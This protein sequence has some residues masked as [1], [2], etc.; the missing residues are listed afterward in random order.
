MGTRA[1][2]AATFVVGVLVET[3]TAL[4]RGPFAEGGAFSGLLVAQTYLAT[5]AISSLTAAALMTGLVSRDALALHD[6]LTGLANRRLLL[7]RL[8]QA[9]RRL[10]RFHSGIGLVYADLDGFKQINDVHGHAAGDEVLI[11]TAERLSAVV[12]AND[13]V[14]RLGGD[15]FVVLLDDLAGDAALEDLMSRMTRAI[16]DPIVLTDGPT[17]SV[18]ASL[19][20]AVTSDADE[21]AEGFL[22]RADRAMYEVKRS[23]R[24]RRRPA[25]A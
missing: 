11:A 9:L 8:T 21:D 3:L 4:D 18:G 7:E 20:C 1:A 12:R 10:G 24:A 14:A 2:A 5:C 13:T 22:D 25:P 19:G 6:S 23:G 15:E 17:V 16:E